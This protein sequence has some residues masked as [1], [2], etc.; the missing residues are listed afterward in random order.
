[1]V[2]AACW[3]CDAPM[4]IALLNVEGVAQAPEDFSE[5]DRTVACEQGVLLRM[6][7]SRTLREKYLSSTCG[8]C[9]AFVG[10]F[11]LHEYW[12]LM[13]AENGHATGHVCLECD[14]HY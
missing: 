8:H 1:M 9:G 12:D 4:K 6:N 3:Q 2:G 14:R 5:R 10:T 13:T 11:F 7:Y